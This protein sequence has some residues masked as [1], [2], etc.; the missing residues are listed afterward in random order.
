MPT[1]STK[2]ES[3]GVAEDI[4]LSFKEYEDLKI[5]AKEM[6][7]AQC[8]GKVSF[9]FAPTGVSFVLKDGPSGGWASKAMKENKYRGKRYKEMG[10]RQKD[11]AFKPHLIPN[12]EG[13][14][15]ENWKEARDMSFENAYAETK[16]V[17]LAKDISSTFDKHVAKEQAK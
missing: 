8:E 17:Q 2:C 14:L 1:Y 4:R 7:C 15:T 12:V 11:H 10:K 3:C 5:G 16:N 13:K 9:V 6:S